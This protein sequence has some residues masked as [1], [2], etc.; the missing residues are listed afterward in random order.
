[1]SSFLFLIV[2]LAV[3]FSLMFRLYTSL[4]HTRNLKC[5]LSVGKKEVERILLTAFFSHIPLNFLGQL[6]FY[7][8][9][10]TNIQWNLIR[11]KILIL[12]VFSWILLTLDTF[13]MNSSYKLLI[14][15]RAKVTQLY[16]GGKKIFI[17]KLKYLQCFVT[18][19]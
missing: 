8:Q 2:Y 1:M 5:M 12:K 11:P 17:S 13:S 4:E 19:K 9:A 15:T 10:S 18:S 6:R 3:H 16:V 7:L 14:S